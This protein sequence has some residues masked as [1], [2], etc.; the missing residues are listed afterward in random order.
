MPC[1]NIP[2][3]KKGCSQAS[4]F[5]NPFNQLTVLGTVDLRMKDPKILLS[6]Q[7]G[8]LKSQMAGI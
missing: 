5:F 2:L 4:E 8:Y 3:V 7:P 6:V 1:C